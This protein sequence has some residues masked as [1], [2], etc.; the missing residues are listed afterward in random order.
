M[1]STS[2]YP[3]S[4][5]IILLTVTI[6]IHKTILY[7]NTKPL[8][9]FDNI[10]AHTLRNVQLRVCV[11]MSIKLSNMKSGLVLLGIIINYL[12]NEFLR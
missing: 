1:I 7:S 5:I 10:F 2:T 9:I 12:Q 4:C 3:K 6:I 8:F 11:N